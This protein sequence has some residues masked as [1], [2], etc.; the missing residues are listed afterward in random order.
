MW[1]NPM[2]LLRVQQG[3]IESHLV[4]LSL[5]KEKRSIFFLLLCCAPHDDGDSLG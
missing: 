4:S 3:E 2:P 1:N 5:S